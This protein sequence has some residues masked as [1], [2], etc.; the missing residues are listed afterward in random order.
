MLGIEHTV[1]P[2]RYAHPMNRAITHFRRRSEGRFLICWI[3]PA[4]ASVAVVSVFPLCTPHVGAADDPVTAS[5]D[6]D[7]NA[8]TQSISH[9]RVMTSARWNGCTRRVQ[10]LN[11]LRFRIYVPTSRLWH[12]WTHTWERVIRLF[13]RRHVTLHIFIWPTAQFSTQPGVQTRCSQLRRFVGAAFP[14]ECSVVIRAAVP[15]HEAGSIYG[16]FA[17]ATFCGR[18]VSP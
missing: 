12:T 17:D 4:A 2:K 8:P 13:C 9:C 14:A 5:S 11:T 3:K 1:R 15:L 7:W 6:P 18:A 10:H 16:Y